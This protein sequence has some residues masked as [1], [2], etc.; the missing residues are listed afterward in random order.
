MS[1]SKSNNHTL[2]L[3]NDF[4]DVEMGELYNIEKSESEPLRKMTS[5]FN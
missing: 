1:R 2:L 5:G 4:E 3:A